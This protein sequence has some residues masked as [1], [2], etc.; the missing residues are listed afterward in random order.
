MTPYVC[1]C[2][3]HCQTV[4]LLLH[5]KRKVWE[6]CMSGVFGTL[7]M[8]DSVVGGFM[9]RCGARRED[10][11]HMPL[12]AKMCMH[13]FCLLPL[14]DF[15]PLSPNINTL[16]TCIL[17]SSTFPILPLQARPAAP[18]QL[19]VHY[20]A[21]SLCLADGCTNPLPSALRREGWAC[22]RRGGHGASVWDSARRRPREEIKRRVIG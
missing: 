14:L 13:S 9:C 4:Y 17:F 6:L 7:Q 20:P 5:R 19:R 3:R 22:V 8:M 12:W 11:V 2:V 18:S 15:L 10:S 21:V 1:V 16:L